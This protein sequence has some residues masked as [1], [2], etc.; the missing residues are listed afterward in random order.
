MYKM[1]YPEYCEMMRHR[2]E[3]PMKEDEFIEWQQLNYD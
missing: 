2:D 3:E 1:T